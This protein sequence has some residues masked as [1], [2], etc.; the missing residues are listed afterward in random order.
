MTPHPVFPFE[1]LRG[2]GDRFRVANRMTAPGSPVIRTPDQR[3]RVF[4]SSTIQELAQERTVATR[5]IRGLKV[6]RGTGA[7]VRSALARP[8][9]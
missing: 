6:R 2:P 9:P 3:V 5:S 4:V 8:V 1:A 7:L